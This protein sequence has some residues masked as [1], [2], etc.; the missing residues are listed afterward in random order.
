MGTTIQNALR[1]LTHRLGVR[2]A[3][4]MLLPMS[5]RAKLVRVYKRIQRVGQG[6]VLFVWIPKTAGSS[7]Y[8]ILAQNGCLKLQ[9]IEE[10]RGFGNRGFV[11][12][13]HMSI[14]DLLAKAL[15]EE[16]YAHNAFKFC[17][18]RN[19]WERLVSLFFYLK[20]SRYLVQPNDSFADFC[21]RI[22]REDIAPVGLYNSKGLSQCN[23]QTDWIFDKNGTIFVDY[24]GRYENLDAD[25]EEIC[26]IIGVK[27]SL[28]HINKS[29]HGDYKLYYDDKTKK[30]VEQVYEKDIELLKYRFG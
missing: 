9:S 17:F 13:G 26:R 11:T 27:G 10:V 16:K 25:V 6:D 20:K 21:L 5:L 22:Q 19:P 15:I 23:P 2:Q 4:L 28:P 18:V 14:P 3:T 24:I 7:I 30:I 29:S 12:F 8:D 1:E